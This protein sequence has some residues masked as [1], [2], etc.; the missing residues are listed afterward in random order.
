M[1]FSDGV[2]KEEKP[3]GWDRESIFLTGLIIF[4]IIVPPPHALPSKGG[5]A[6][7]MHATTLVPP[8][9]LPAPPLPVHIGRC[10]AQVLCCVFYGFYYLLSQERASSMKSSNKR[11]KQFGNPQQ[12]YSRGG[13]GASWDADEF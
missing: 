4:F 1:W 9:P 8:P 13:H 2:K 12:Q 11:P 3:K 6:R 5:V 7:R 10:G